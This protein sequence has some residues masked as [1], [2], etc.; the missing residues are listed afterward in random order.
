VTR[1]ARIAV[2]FIAASAL[3]LG[4][5]GPASARPSSG[6]KYGGTLV[7]NVAIG[8]P[9]T[10]DPTLSGASSPTEIYHAMCQQL[11]DRGPGGRLI[12]VLAAAAPALSKDKLSYTIQLRRGVQFNDG[13]PFNAAAVVNTVQRFMTYPGS[14]RAIDYT[15]VASV[16]ASG[17]YAVVYHLKARDST[18]IGGNS[19]MLS[20]AALA[21]EGDN[22]GADPVCVG[23]FMFDHRVPGD[24]ITLIKSPY[25]YDKGHVYL[26]K[27]VFKFITVTAAATAA[28]QAGDVQVLDSVSTTVLPAVQ[29]DSS[30]Q[31]ISSPELGWSGVVFNIGNM[32][33]ASNPPYTNLGTPFASSPK[34]RL[35]FEEAIDRNALNKVVYSGL[36]QVSCTMISPADKVWFD[37]TKVPCTPYDPADARR[38]V[39]AS[40]FPNPT[41]HL[42]GNSAS[43]TQRKAQ[44]IQAE[45]AAV[46]INVVIDTGDLGTI[47]AAEQ[48]GYFE[49]RI[50][51]FMPGGA[52]PDFNISGAVRSSGARNY[53][54]YS[55]PRLDLILSNGLKA[56]SFKAR[57]TLYHVAQQ[58]IATDRPLLV[59]YSPTA[60]AA[61]STNVTGIHLNA[62]GLLIVENAQYR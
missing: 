6:P 51:T 48:K 24:N 3:A 38:L 8:E 58:I 4:A 59:F 26:D 35:A 28:L 53:M 15:D 46:G 36:E 21:A 20:P 31:V 5:F 33:G 34:L 18:F 61:F 54:G 37:A 49:I 29:Q 39:A 13:T 11:Y 7:V 1:Q 12:P 52:D 44:F 9:A 40:G 17:Q 43:D 19:Y 23:P 60:I 14:G 47:S 45:E 32:N 41:V 2:A 50:G 30:L 57:A 22:F 27:L 42:L 10:L 62:S 55:N 16:T 25:Y 56:T